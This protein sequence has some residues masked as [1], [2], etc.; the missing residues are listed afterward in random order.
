MNLKPHP[1]SLYVTFV[2]PRPWAK[3]IAAMYVIVAASCAW[4]SL[5]QEPG[6]VT[7][8]ALFAASIGVVLFYLY[9]PT[10]RRRAQQSRR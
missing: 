8:W 10:P 2:R 5:R 9:L 4:S 6:N 1:D 3:T 7:T